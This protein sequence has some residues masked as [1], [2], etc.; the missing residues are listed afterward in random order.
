M[1]ARQ[2]VGQARLRFAAT[3]LAAVIG[4]L[5]GALLLDALGWAVDP[6]PL[7]LIMLVAT[8]LC[9][10]I[11]AVFRTRDL[12]V[13]KHRLDHQVS[14]RPA[15][16][17]QPWE[18]QPDRQAP[19][20]WQ[21]FNSGPLNPDQQHSSPSYST[22][23]DPSLALNQPDSSRAEALH[24]TPATTAPAY[25]VIAV[26][27]PQAATSADGPPSEAWWNQ[28]EHSPMAPGA[29]APRRQAP[30][31]SS[32]IESGLIVQCT[33]CAAF[34]ID[35]QRVATGFSF[36]CQACGHEFT[37]QRNEEWPAWKVSPQSRSNP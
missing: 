15:P 8:A 31:I 18:Q 11:G 21:G 23:P 25:A 22:W 26:D 12:A 16:S 35:V 28:T 7:G 10:G 20:Q 29:G 6:L 1:M 36:R 5:L 37:W 13:R 2:Y 19:S 4:S 17:P 30:D 24:P 14:P 33:R 9:G 3:I 32:Y 34:T 27:P